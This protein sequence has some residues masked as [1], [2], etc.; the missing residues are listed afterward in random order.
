[1]VSV[2]DSTRR[3]LGL[4]AIALGVALIA[5]DTTIVNVIVP[6]IISDLGVTSVQAQWIQ[7]SYAIVFAALL[8]LV[9][10]AADI[11]GARRGFIT[12][13]VLFGATTLLAGPAPNG[14]LVVAAR[15]LQGARRQQRSLK[16]HHHAEIGSCACT[17]TAVTPSNLSRI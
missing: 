16:R 11:L 15:F 8:L 2:T 17:A 7:E 4:I 5:V 13:V 14:E 1:M 10:R 12:G 3:W 9:A 6:S